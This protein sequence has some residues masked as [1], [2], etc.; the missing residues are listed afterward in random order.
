[1]N[2]YKPFDRTVVITRQ[3]WKETYKHARVIR[4][5][6]ER[7]GLMQQQHT[8][9]G[10]VTVPTRTPYRA[11]ETDPNLICVDWQYYEM[12]KM[13]EKLFVHRK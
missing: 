11:V 1:M 8:P 10:Y 13:D 12:C 2:D 5:W 6:N 9:N 4:R 7:L 3:E